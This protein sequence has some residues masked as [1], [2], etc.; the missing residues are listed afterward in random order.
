MRA[1]EL[2]CIDNHLKYMIY[3]VLI[4]ILP[5]C[6]IVGMLWGL[7][8]MLCGLFE[9]CNEWKYEWKYITKTIKHRG[10]R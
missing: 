6:L 3:L 7:F 8:E 4:L 2:W 9:M 10:K 5:I 1:W